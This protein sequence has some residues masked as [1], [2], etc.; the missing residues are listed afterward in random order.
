MRDTRVGA[1]D[2]LIETVGTIDLR[3]S[4]AC[5]VNWGW[6]QL[7]DGVFYYQTHDPP[8]YDNTTR[9]FDCTKLPECDQPVT[10]LDLKEY[11]LDH[12]LV[13]GWNK[14]GAVTYKILE[15]TTEEISMLKSLQCQ[16]YTSVPYD[17]NYLFFNRCLCDSI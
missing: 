3:Q 7:H 1:V 14:R 2:L 6:L 4:S 5:S 17:N 10:W 12:D 16:Q 15:L 13:V 9:L 11:L 8:L